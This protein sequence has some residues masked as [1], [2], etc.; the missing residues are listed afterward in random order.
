MNLICLFVFSKLHYCLVLFVN[1]VL[2]RWDNAADTV[3]SRICPKVELCQTSRYM[4]VEAEVLSIFTISYYVVYTPDNDQ[5]HSGSRTFL[6][7][8]KWFKL[9]WSNETHQLNMW[10][11][12]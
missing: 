12:K 4:L 9:W 6:M 5:W 7:N 11:H 10:Q 2:T 1:N 8:Y 3:D